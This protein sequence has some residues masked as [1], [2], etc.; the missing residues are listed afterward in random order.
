MPPKAPK[1]SVVMP[2][3]NGAKY[4]RQAIESVLS[5]TFCEFEF[6]IVDDC[7]ADASIEI[8]RSYGD[9]RI[10]LVC[11]ETNRGVAQ[12]CN[13]GISRSQGVYIARMDADDI[14]LPER[15]TR[16]VAFLDTHAQH[17]VVGTWAEIWTEDIKTARVHRHPTE[18]IVLKYELLFDNYFVHSSVMVRADVFKIIGPYPIGPQ[19]PFPEDYALWSRVARHF[20]MANLAEYLHIYREVPASQSRQQSLANHVVRISAANLAYVFGQ[21]DPDQTLID[22]AAY[23]HGAYTVIPTPAK[24]MKWVSLLVKAADKLSGADQMS[25]KLLRRRAHMRAK[26]LLRTYAG[27]IL[28][29]SPITK[30]KRM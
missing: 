13:I 4:L 29:G 14:S 17:G 12:S 25:R 16:Q 22:L 7:S 30:S 5:Q 1:V 19:R 9:P 8:I 11:N 18:S 20:D 23:V 26:S 6:I 2:V 28:R 24:A 15:F 3:Y 10:K 21:S 27:Q